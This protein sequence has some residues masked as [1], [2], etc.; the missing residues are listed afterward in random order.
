MAVV[1]PQEHERVETLGFEVT[2]RLMFRQDGRTGT[3]Y[4]LN[5]TSTDTTPPQGGGFLAIGEHLPR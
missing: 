2:G 1:L 3:G 5:E 4:C